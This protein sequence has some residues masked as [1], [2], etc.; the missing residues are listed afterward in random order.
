VSPENP[1]TARVAANRLWQQFFGTGLA[2]T[3]EDVGRQGEPPVPEPA[4]LAVLGVGALA[5][6]RRKRKA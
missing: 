2:K 4:S 6:L 3:S 5:L 1:L